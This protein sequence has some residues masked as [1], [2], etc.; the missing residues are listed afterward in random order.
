M[1]LPNPPLLYLDEN[2]SPRLAEQL[3]KYGFDAIAVRESNLLAR[4]DAE[5]FAFAVAQRRTLVT[6]NF[7]DFVSLH[8]AYLAEGRPHFGIVFTTEERFG[9]LLNRLLNLLNSVSADDLNNQIRWL[10]EFR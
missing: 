5:Q 1:P 6:I 9:I 2:L 8:E 4:S 7:K 10:N 3:R